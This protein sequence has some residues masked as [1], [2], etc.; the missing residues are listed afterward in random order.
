MIGD[1]TNYFFQC[2]H[3]FFRS[4][5]TILCLIYFSLLILPAIGQTPN[6]I[7]NYP[8]NVYK[9][10][11][12]VFNIVKD[13]SGI[14]YFGT[15]KGVVI[16]DGERWE[17]IPI[18]NFS[19]A[20]CLEKGPNGKI[21]VGANGN[22]GF[23]EKDIYTGYKYVSMSD[24][25][26]PYASNFND[27]WQIV[28]LNDDIYFQ[29]YSGIFKW[30]K[31]NITFDKIIDVYIYNIDNQLYA[32][33][34]IGGKFGKFVDGKIHP[35]ADFPKL[36]EDLVFQILEYLPN[37]YLLA[38][39]ESGLFLFNSTTEEITKFES[40]VNSFLEQYSF[41]DGLRISPDLYGLGSWEGGIAFIDHEGKILNKI[42]QENGLYANHIYDM[43]VGN[44]NDLWLATSN[45]ISRIALDSL[46]FEAKVDNQIITKPLLRNI[47]FSLSNESVEIY[48]LNETSQ[49][50]EDKYLIENGVVN[51]YK[52]PS[53]LSFYFAT[54]GFAGEETS[55]SVFLDGYDMKWSEWKSDPMKEYTNL[56]AGSYTFYLQSKKDIDSSLSEVN[57]ININIYA[58]WYQST[59]IKV[60]ILFFI[61][62]GIYF[63]VRLMILRLK[64][65][66]T[67]LEKI[68][69]ERTQSLVDQQKK[70]SEVNKNLTVSNRE[71]DSFVYHT[72]HDLKAPLKSVLGLVDL[73]KREDTQS[74]FSQYHNLME[75]SIHKLEEFISSIIQY[76][77][78]S[79]SD[80]HIKSID[81]DSLIK[82]AIDEIQFHEAFDQIEILQN[83][84]ANGNF[85][86]DE[87]RIQ[88]VINN[89]ISNAIKYYDKRKPTPQISIDINQLDK[90]VE[91]SIKD[92]GIG[93]KAEYQ[94]KVFNMFYRASERSYG[95]GL[96]L[97]IIKETIKKLEGS[98]HLDSKYGEYTNF[99]IH[100]P[101]LK[102]AVTV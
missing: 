36:Q 17:L 34:Y 45:G 4:I 102:E 31:G 89:L 85:Y 53:S 40:E 59:W 84:H 43:K 14:I 23:L 61:L 67:R 66:N 10:S 46:G 54:P 95:S 90:E 83:I 26:P 32:S 79:K 56:S 11:P 28:F 3:L 74:K 48:Q 38:T 13:D 47:N 99:T 86:S 55:Y 30:S 25:L 20:K 75:S 72:S 93:I 9:A 24:S 50:A 94:D 12:A 64:I 70:L 96:G 65:Q 49:F 87:K 51:I 5:I 77:S 73:A 92:N 58:P 35:F 39:S 76:S 29:T 80:V 97:Y 19:G 98:I 42:N 16:F 81:F 27:V 15:N 44:N 1:F 82:N 57:S 88:I 63:I 22:F 33:S 101:N 60:L 7:K 2:N 71:L 8:P 78:N 41:F 21:Y 69:S 52:L 37:E 100:L 6:Y 18:S 68:I 62:G 91:I